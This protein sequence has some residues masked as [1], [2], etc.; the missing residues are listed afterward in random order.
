MMAMAVSP[1][2]RP[3]GIRRRTA[4]VTVWRTGES[5]CSSR[6]A[7]RQADSMNRPSPPASIRYSGQWV[8][9]AVF[10]GG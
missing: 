9:R 1:M 8:R 2:A 5:G 6:A 7:N 4:A 3:I 10:T